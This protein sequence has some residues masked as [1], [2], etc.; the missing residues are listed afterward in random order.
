M[1]GSFLPI[2][3]ISKF[4]IMDREKEFFLKLKNFKITKEEFIE[5]IKRSRRERAI[6]IFNF[7]IKDKNV[8]YSTIID[9]CLLWK[10]T[11]QGS[12]FWRKIC[13]EIDD[14]KPKQKIKNI[15]IKVK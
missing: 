5:Q 6:K 13:E 7:L 3:S 1:Q 4:S 15:K 11:S 9:N 14:I 2:A 10:M 8:L 12:D